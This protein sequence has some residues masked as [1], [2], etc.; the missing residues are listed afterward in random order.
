MGESN[1]SRICRAAILLLS[2]QL[3]ACCVAAGSAPG[4]VTLESALILK[5]F[6]IALVLISTIFIA[7]IIL[8]LA[9][10]LAYISLRGLNMKMLIYVLVGNV[11]SFPAG[12]LTVVL[13]SYF[14]PNPIITLLLSG[15]LVVLL[16]SLFL[17][18]PSK[19]SISF[20]NALLLSLLLNAAGL[21]AEWLAV[22]YA[23]S[24]MAGSV[25]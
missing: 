13:L 12:F 16:E 10:A 1:A 19:K 22:A 24:L 11:I 5:T 4:I 21:L 23:S 17:Y 25:L 15:L 18:Y 2:I 20:R 7:P 9:I 14:L 3:L 6:R 8:E